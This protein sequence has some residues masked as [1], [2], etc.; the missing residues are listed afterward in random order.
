MPVDLV[1]RFSRTPFV[2][3]LTLNCV[4]VR[5]ATNSQLLLDRLVVVS[6]TDKE[7]HQ[8]V[9]VV[10]WRIVVEDEGDVSDGAPAP[11]SF[12]QDGLSIIRIAHRSFLASDRQARL[13]I[14]FISGKLLEEA[15][16]FNRY[17][18]PALMSITAQMKE[19]V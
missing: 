5:V 18:F 10:E 13:G 16:L 6:T 8:G 4:P 17:F 15:H 1:Q 14:S 2:A 11:H 3:D 12:T 9:S 19:R 7:H